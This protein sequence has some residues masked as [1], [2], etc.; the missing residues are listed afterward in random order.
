MRLMNSL[1]SATVSTE[2][3]CRYFRLASNF[4]L[5]GLFIQCLV[6]YYW[7]LKG[8]GLDGSLPI[9]FRLIPCVPLI[10]CFCLLLFSP[11]PH[12]VSKGAKYWKPLCKAAFFIFLMSFAV[13][14]SLQNDMRYVLSDSYRFAMPWFALW[15]FVGQYDHLRGSA[16]HGEVLRI[17]NVVL[18]MACLDGIATFFLAGVMDIRVS[19]FFH[20]FAICWAVFQCHWPILFSIFA[21]SIGMVGLIS[22]GKRGTFV[23]FCLTIPLMIC[24]MFKGKMIR[25]LVLG[26]LFSAIIGASLIPSLI[27]SDSQ[28]GTTFNRTVGSLSKIWDS[29]ESGSMDG[30]I[31]EIEN[32]IHFF[33]KNPLAL[34]TGGGFG[35]EVEMF[36]YSGVFSRNGLMHQVHVGWFAYLFRNGIAGVVLLAFFWWKALAPVSP[37][38]LK[39]LNRMQCIFGTYIAFQFILSFKSQ[40]MLEGLEFPFLIAV[41]ANLETDE[42]S[43]KNIG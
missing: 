21:A 4:A 35:A 9:Q 17:C 7:L 24:Y 29:G 11:K 26:S 15:I 32:V 14:I 18:V 1:T 37:L 6:R 30:R 42:S 41:S 31:A 2:Q 38:S 10:L 43:A 20:V 3:D 22:S 5:S 36:K 28:L 39:K 8:T 34:F 33:Q 23:G 40:I 19:T 13:G 25:Q 12:Y 27:A 16:I